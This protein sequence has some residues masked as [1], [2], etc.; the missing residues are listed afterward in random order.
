MNFIKPSQSPQWIEINPVRSKWKFKHGHFAKINSIH[1][2]HIRCDV[3][4][5]RFMRTRGRYPQNSGT[6][7]LDIS[8]F[9]PEGV[10]IFFTNTKLSQV[11]IPKSP[12]I[13]AI[14]KLHQ[15]DYR[16]TCHPCCAHS[17][18][19]RSHKSQVI[20]VLRFSGE[21]FIIL[22]LNLMDSLSQPNEQAE[23][24]QASLLFIEG[25][26]STHPIHP[27]PFKTSY[28]KARLCR[29]RRL[30]AL[31]IA[32]HR[33]YGGT[34]GRIRCTGCSQWCTYLADR[35]SQKQPVDMEG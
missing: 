17:I 32:L 8:V 21:S 1:P 4:L 31:S 35:G 20:Q 2:K 26:R 33:C 18:S 6:L 11:N 25:K 28:G 15:F 23:H 10:D 34:H 5:T 3:S 12:A 30:N 27:V 24:L 22:K 9:F 29:L 7:P 19:K 16:I 13:F 14:Y